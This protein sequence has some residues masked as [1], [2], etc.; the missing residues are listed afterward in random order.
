MLRQ[1]GDRGCR[2]IHLLRAEKKS[3]YRAV[4]HGETWSVPWELT[5]GRDVPGA[6]DIVGLPVHSR[7]TSWARDAPQGVED[8]VFL[9]AARD[10]NELFGEDP[11]YSEVVGKAL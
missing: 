5:V 2:A 8:E 4:R 10:V 1:H 9:Q 6:E 3:V 11:A 7:I